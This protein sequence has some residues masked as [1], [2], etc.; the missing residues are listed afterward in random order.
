MSTNSERKEC[1]N[2]RGITLLNVTYKYKNIL[3]EIK[4]VPQSNKE[5]QLQQ[6]KQ[7]QPENWI[8]SHVY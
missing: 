4:F 2:Y 6:L 8:P 7:V 3:K 1:E 5:A